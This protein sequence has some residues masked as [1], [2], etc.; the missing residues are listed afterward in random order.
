MRLLKNT[1]GG[2]GV[3]MKTKH[4]VAI[5]VAGIGAAGLVASAIIGAAWGKN[6]IDLNLTINDREV[7]LM[8]RV[9]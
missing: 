8:I 3:D 9:I 1:I 6:N 2:K 5:V 7:I 4:I